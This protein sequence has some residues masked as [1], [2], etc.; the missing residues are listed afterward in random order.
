MESGLDDN[1]A[2][3]ELAA[4]MENF[5]SDLMMQPDREQVTSEIGVLQSIYGANAIHLWHGSRVGSPAYASDGNPQSNGTDTIRY[6]ISLIL[7]S[8]EDVSIRI[9]VSLP[10]SYP[11]ESPPQLQLLSRYIGAYG[12][13]TSLFG[14]ILRTFISISGVEWTRDTVCVFDGLQSILERAE[15][16]YEDKL[17]REKAGELIR[18]DALGRDSAP[19][20]PVESTNEDGEGLGR[21]SRPTPPLQDVALPEGIKLI[22]ADPI[23]DRKSVFVGRACQISDPSQVPLILNHLISDRHIARAAHPIINAWRCQVGNVLHQ[24]NDDDGET[25]AGNRLAHLLS[26]LE[27]NNVLV[28]VTR[29]FGG[30]HLGPDRFK[31]I[32]HAARNALEMGGFLDQVEGSKGGAKGRKR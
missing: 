2:D 5:V 19:Q 16:W 23:V 30:I 3:S 1:A 15:A 14:S 24:D 22:E 20:V 32:N 25:A 10:P 9:L 31:H 12:V 17:N 11:A 26:I 28:V 13:D 27:I 29:W 7:P 6:V 18:E 4:E 8:H 21:V